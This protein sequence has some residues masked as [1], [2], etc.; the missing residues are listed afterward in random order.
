MYN[1]NRTYNG[2]VLC[3]KKLISWRLTKGQPV[4]GRLFLIKGRQV[5]TSQKRV[6][7]DFSQA[8]WVEHNA[9]E[10][11]NSVQSVIAGALSK[12]ALSQIRLKRLGLPINGRQR[13][14]GIKRR[15]THLQCDRLAVSANSFFSRKAQT[16]WICRLLSSKTGLIIDAYF[17]AT[18]VRWILDHV[19]GA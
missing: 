11:W 9:N 13:L 14:C 12:V 16:R 1:K 15:I 17:S 18:K 10:I 5:A 8:G 6:Y 7:S 4:H 2:G 3:H 19:E